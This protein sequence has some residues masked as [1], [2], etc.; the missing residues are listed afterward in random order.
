M[1]TIAIEFQTSLRRAS[2]KHA[3]KLI[4]AGDIKRSARWSGP[5]S[6]AEDDYIEERGFLEYA[7]WHLGLDEEATPDTKGR[8][9]YPFTDD[10]KTISINGLNAIRSRSAQNDE[11]DIFDEAGRLLDLI[12]ERGEFTSR[13]D[14]RRITFQMTGGEVDR[15][16]GT[17]TGV[18]IIENGEARGHRMM[19]SERTLDTVDALIAGQVL[20]AYV[21]H[22]GAHVDRLMSEVGAFSEFYRDGDKIRAGRFEVLPSFREHEPERFDRLFDLAEKMPATFGISIVFEGSLFWETSEGDEPFDGFADR[23]DGASFEYPTVKPGRIFSADFVDTP[24]ATA[25]LFAEQLNDQTPIESMSEKVTKL[26]ESASAE[27]ERR[28][29]AEEAEEGNAPPAPAEEK[30]AKKKAAKKKALAEDDDDAGVP[31]DCAEGY[32]EVDGECVPEPDAEDDDAEDAEAPDEIEADED[33]L[34]PELLDAT[35]A[36]YTTRISERDI[37]IAGQSETIAE[38]QTENRAFRRALVGAEEMA[39]EGEAEI[40]DDSPGAL[41]DAAIKEY[42]ERHPTHN[43]I[44]A[45]LEVGKANPQIFNN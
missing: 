11:T 38:L 25:S 45:I 33:R 40:K 20:P 2:I 37:L 36:E 43:R 35:L 39:A 31:P 41:K 13:D 10:F 1:S 26:D 15:E 6:R 21:S 17:I 7:D 12:K 23:P 30:P 18:N 24:A 9:R 27:L 5:S 42:L 4:K 44:T 29:A 14:A 22:S 32:V 3:R 28:L 19:I 8:F 34:A 16:A